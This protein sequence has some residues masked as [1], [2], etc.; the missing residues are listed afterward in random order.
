MKSILLFFIFFISGTLA[1]SQ[2]QA[3][4]FIKEAQQFLAEKKYKEAQL[5]LQDAINDINA[6]LATQVAAGMPTEINGLKADG[7]GEINTAGMGMIGGGLQI[8]KQYVHPAKKENE[9]DVS[10]MSNSPM[11][12]SINMFMSN[13]AMLGEGYKSVRVGSRRAILKTQMEDYYDDN[14]ASKKIRASELQ[15]PLSQTLIS[16]NFKGFATEAEELAFATKLDIDKLSD[17][18]GE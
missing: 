6:I 3:D 11:L 8:T 17:L 9:A 16:I 18:L 10:I 12:A 13:P 5:S 1:F 14:G 15:I 7:D 4:A 2:S